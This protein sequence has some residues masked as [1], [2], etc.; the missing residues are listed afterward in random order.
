M[1]KNFTL[2]GILLL[3]FQNISFAQKEIIQS[4]TDKYMKIILTRKAREGIV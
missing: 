1:K 4:D 2:V 3:L